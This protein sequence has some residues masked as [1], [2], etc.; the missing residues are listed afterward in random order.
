[1]KKTP[2]SVPMRLDLRRLMPHSKVFTNDYYY[3][4]PNVSE[5]HMYLNL[6]QIRELFRL[7]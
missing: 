2:E 1:M 3:L 7:F 6:Y 4:V 5:Y